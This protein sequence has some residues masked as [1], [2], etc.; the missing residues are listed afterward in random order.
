LIAIHLAQDLEQVIPLSS[1]IIEI[2]RS[3]PGIQL[4]INSNYIFFRILDNLPTLDTSFK[5]SGL[6]N[7][8]N[9]LEA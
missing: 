6:H 5:K 2:G 9:G 1:D 7:T 8:I 4:S 3:I